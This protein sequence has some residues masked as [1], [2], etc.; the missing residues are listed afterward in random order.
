MATVAFGLGVDKADV[1]RV[2]HSSL[3]KSVENYVQETGRAG[4]D[5]LPATCHLI[6]SRQDAE[7][8]MSLAHANRLCQLQVAAMLLEVFVVPQKQPQKT[9][10]QNSNSTL[11]SLRPLGLLYEVVA[12][13]VD[14]LQVRF[15]CAIATQTVVAYIYPLASFYTLSGELRR[16]R[17][18]GGD[19]PFHPRT[20]VLRSRGA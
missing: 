20:P 5:G 4:R 6:V 11:S 9:V 2:V 10:H 15:T 7:Q 1:R 17:R 18:R 3:P 14:R 13:S 19:G 8:Q 16:C 12:V